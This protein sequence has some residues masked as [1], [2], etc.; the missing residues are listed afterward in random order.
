MTLITKKGLR[1][2]MCDAIRYGETVDMPWDYEMMFDYDNGMFEMHCTDS[3]NP[4]DFNGYM[5]DILWFYE[6][7]WKGD[8]FNYRRVYDSV[9]NEGCV[10]TLDGVEF[11]FDTPSG[12][13]YADRMGEITVIYG[14]G[15][16]R[17]FMEG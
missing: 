10:E 15:D 5:E 8:E 16:F 6:D 3:M 11:K 2:L 1:A 13:M 4:N 9:T 14:L 17:K 12:Q 7:L